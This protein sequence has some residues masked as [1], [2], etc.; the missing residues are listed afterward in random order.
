MNEKD[1]YLF[2]NGLTELKIYISCVRNVG[3]K[4]TCLLPKNLGAVTN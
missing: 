1:P 2:L 3:E 4:M